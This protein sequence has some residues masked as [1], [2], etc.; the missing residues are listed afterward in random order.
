M[1]TDLESRAREKHDLL[2]ARRDDV[3]SILSDA[4]SIQLERHPEPSTVDRQDWADRFGTAQHVEVAGRELALALEDER[5]LRLRIAGDGRPADAGV[6]APE[7]QEV[8]VRQTELRVELRYALERR[9]RAEALARRVNRLLESANAELLATDRRIVWAAEQRKRTDGLRAALGAAPLDTIADDATAVLDSPTFDAA[10]NRLDELLPGELRTRA[11]ERFDDAATVLND[12]RSH[13]NTGES[14]VAALAG[15]AHKFEAP[16]ET[17]T[18]AYRAAQQ[19]LAEYVASAESVL[20]AATPM[21]T[22]IAAHPD[23]T[24]AQHDALHVDAP[25]ASGDA[26]AA[27]GSL[28]AAL[29]LARALQRDIDDAITAALTVDP[30]ADPELDD[31][32]IAAREALADAAI[33]D[34]IATARGEYDARAASNLEAEV[35][36]S[37]WRALGDFLSVRTALERL[38]DADTAAD[39]LDDLGAAEDAL[40]AALD[41]RDKAFRTALMVSLHVA[42]RE[43][44]AEAAE[45]TQVDRAVHYL[46]GEGPA[47]RT[48]VE[49]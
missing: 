48:P 29:V 23:L 42:E 20:E 44:E 17:A 34:P 12:A 10:N 39:L 15:D 28:A 47:G 1:A 21:L 19:S 45:R 9:T 16:V 2:L 26:L 30:D 41:A 22:A 11:S 43:A 27:E 35:P 25:A 13:R 4:Q 37:L 46:R 3:R 5:A 40:G 18:A 49:L 32:V 33:Q 38:G 14:S 31:D 36:E 8:L 24:D 7:L 6:L